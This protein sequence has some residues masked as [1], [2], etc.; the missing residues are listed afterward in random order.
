ML[1]FE[2]PLPKAASAITRS[3]RYRGV[4]FA[5]VGVLLGSAAW[6]GFIA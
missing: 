5:L 1:C 2:A 3:K 4:A 6:A